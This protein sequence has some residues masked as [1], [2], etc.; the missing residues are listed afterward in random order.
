MMGADDPLIQV[1]HSSWTTRSFTSAMH[2]RL[3]CRHAGRCHDIP[4]PGITHPELTAVLIYLAE[5]NTSD[6]T[7]V[8]T[9]DDKLTGLVFN[10]SGTATLV[11]NGYFL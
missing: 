7:L 5:G 9:G 6:V 11:G 2:V 4:C 3:D 1:S 10:P 8:G